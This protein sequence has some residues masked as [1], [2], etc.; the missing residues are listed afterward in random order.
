MFL[1]VFF[2]L[3]IKI[4]FLKIRDDEHIESISCDDIYAPACL[5]LILPY[6]VGSNISITDMCKIMIECFDLSTNDMKKYFSILM[7]T[8]DEIRQITHF[9]VYQSNTLYTKFQHSVNVC[10]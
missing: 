10:L 8:C 1:F 7:K 4:Y 9:N 6:T 2:V 5:Y 3:C